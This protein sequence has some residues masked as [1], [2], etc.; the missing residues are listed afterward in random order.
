MAALGAAM[1][2][3]LAKGVSAAIDL[4]VALSEA[5]TLIK[6]TA[7]EM[8]LMR[9]EAS[10]L[11]VQ[12]GTTSTAQVQAYYQAISAG[13]SSVAEA[14][15]MMETANL[16]ALGGVTDITTAVDVLTTAVNAYAGTGLTAAQASD[17]LFAGVKEGKT[18]VGELAAGLG[19]VVPIAAQLG[20]GLT[21][22][23]AA[24]AALTKGGI[25]TSVAFTN[26]KA[27]LSGVLKPTSEAEKLSKALGLEFNSTAL[28]A[29]GLAGF[30]ADVTEKTA[31]NQDAMAMLF[32]SVEALGGVMALGA[33]D[34]KAFADS[35]A[36]VSDN[37]GATQTAA[38]KISG[39]LS[40]RLSVALS[41]VGDWLAKIGTVILTIVV[42]ALEALVGTIGWVI[43]GFA[44]VI[45]DMGAVFSFFAL[46]TKQPAKATQTWTEAVDQQI[47]AEYD[48]QSALRDVSG[49]DR[50]AAEAAIVSA[51][52]NIQ[53]AQSAYKRVEA[54]YAI[55][56][57]LLDRL[58]LE[59]SA[60]KSAN[61]SSNF[62]GQDVEDM[63]T[64]D[65][66]NAEVYRSEVRKAIE[67][68]RLALKGSVV[69]LDK[70]IEFGKGGE[71]IWDPNRKAIEEVVD[72]LDA[73]GVAAALL[74]LKTKK[75]AGAGSAVKKAFD[76]LKDLFASLDR[77]V[78]DLANSMAQSIGDGF[79][80]MVSGT[81]TVAEAFRSMA[82]EII[83]KLY[84]VIVVQQI[85]G[86]FGVKGTPDSGIAGFLGSLITGSGGPNFTNVSGGPKLN[87]NGN[88]FSGGNVIPFASGG[89]VSS[90]TVF[91]MANG[92][93]GLMG[94]AGPEAI[95]PLSRGANGKLGVKS[96][97]GGDTFN[98]YNTFTGGVTQADLG[99][100]LPRVVEASKRAVLD[101]RRRGGSYAAGFG[102]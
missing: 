93:V 58:A 67:A 90:P 63:A 49:D 12:F 100:I 46:A 84:E 99:A 20:I 28:K 17:I 72:V 73:A 101:A 102:G 9:E 61:I 81:K 60:A 53:A 23:T 96:S 59:E 62:F 86:S 5:S 39:S 55:A 79:T 89:V 44:S 57:A 85:V 66:K 98:T 80:D 65:R 19:N 75:A 77:Q 14:T 48:L 51:N 35:L 8:A 54:E 74:G 76:P 1:V 11:A 88:A 13:A 2:A 18:T 30:L 3:A 21:E 94:E 37:A 40:Q 97:G 16:L 50:K 52:A 68:S 34:G 32:G 82:Y 4:D 15:A 31:G 33:N 70:A 91:P 92:G 47:Q 78:N 43:D 26:V 25:K 36:S 71:K 10:R 56:D 45:A 87:A 6:G 69:G 24:T 38:D 27:I 29:K 95:M 7:E 41:T 42:P 83:K 22:V 64:A